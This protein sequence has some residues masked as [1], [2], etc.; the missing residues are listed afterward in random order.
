[1]FGF[2]LQL[3]SQTFLTEKNLARHHPGPIGTVDREF[4]GYN[5]TYSDD[6]TIKDRGK[7]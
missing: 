5:N 2:S 3:L 4:H 1:V 7:K 6:N